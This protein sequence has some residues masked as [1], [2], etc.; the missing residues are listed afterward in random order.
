MNNRTGL[1]RMQHG[2]ATPSELHARPQGLQM[3]QFAT[4][5][6]MPLANPTSTRRGSCDRIRTPDPGFRRS[7]SAGDEWAGESRGRKKCRGLREMLWSCG[8]CCDCIGRFAQRR[9]DAPAPRG[10]TPRLALAAREEGEAR[11]C[12]YRCRVE[13]RSGGSGA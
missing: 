12:L 3:Q 10:Y 8:S 7:S 2:T 9:R 4:I 5:S 1:M 13:S 6:G 11:C